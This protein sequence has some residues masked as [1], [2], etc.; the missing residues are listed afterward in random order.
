MKKIFYAIGIISFLGLGQVQAQEVT[1]IFYEQ[2]LNVF[3][4]AMVGLESAHTISVAIR[5]QWRG[6]Q[7]APQTHTFFNHASYQR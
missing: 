4:P 5:N 2:N 3:N 1:P 6:V 7:D